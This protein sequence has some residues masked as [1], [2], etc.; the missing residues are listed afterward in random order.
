MVISRPDTTGIPPKA[1]F[2][3][4]E[5]RQFYPGMWM[6]RICD[7]HWMSIGYVGDTYLAQPSQS[8]GTATGTCTLHPSIVKDIR[9]SAATHANLCQTLQ[10]KRNPSTFNLY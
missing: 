1:W 8:T 3:A 7:A 5:L 2:Q 9:G 6:Y 4:S 10:W